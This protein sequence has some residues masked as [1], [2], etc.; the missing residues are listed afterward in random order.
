V[1]AHGPL[2]ATTARRTVLSRVTRFGGDCARLV[3]VATAPNEPQQVHGAASSLWACDDGATQRRLHPPP[4]LLSEATTLAVSGAAT[5]MLMETL[6]A[7]GALAAGAEA[8]RA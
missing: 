7:T 5:G 2:T 6:A 1:H 8:A 4:I 3:I